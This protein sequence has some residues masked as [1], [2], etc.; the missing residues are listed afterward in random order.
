M[1][2]T[3]RF[4]AALA[5][6]A[7]VAAPAAA[8]DATTVLA[9]VGTAEITLGH[10]IALRAQLPAQFQQVPDVTLFPAIVEQLIEQEIIAQAHAVTAR[11]RLMLANETRAFL[12]NASMEATAAAAVTEESIAAAYEAFATAFGA[13]DPVTEYRAAHVLVRTE[14][15]MAQVTAALADGRAFA[16][17]AR[18]FSIDGSAQQGGDL[19]WFRAGMMIPDFQAAVE[20]LEVGQVSAPLQTQF[21]FHVINLLETR[22]VGTPPLEVVRDD[23]VT[24]IQRTATR[25]QVDALRAAATVENLSEGVDPA[26]LSQSALLDE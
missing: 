13:G 3:A 21:G 25:A 18:E 8:Q 26:L 22:P 15:E 12:A 1:F 14:E 2:K 10:A 19:G 20:A 17:V 9:R 11:E 16:D 24:Q 7:A 5:L 23:L 6:A 4:A